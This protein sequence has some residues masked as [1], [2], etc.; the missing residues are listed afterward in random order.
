MQIVRLIIF[1]IVFLSIFA[2]M[3]LFLY[4]KLK[5]LF[6]TPLW[7]KT[8][9]LLLLTLFLI[10]PISRNLPPQFLPTRILLMVA[11]LWIG[12][13]FYSFLFLFLSLPFKGSLPNKIALL[14]ALLTVIF[15]FMQSFHIR[16]RTL[17]LHITREGCFLSGG[18]VSHWGQTHQAQVPKWGQVSSP[19]GKQLWS[20]LGRISERE[21][22]QDPEEGQVWKQKRPAS[23]TF[24]TEKG[25]VQK[26]PT[27]GQVL[28][29]R[30]VFLSDLHISI[31]PPSSF[32]KS[33]VNRINSLK[34]D[35]ILMGGAIIEREGLSRKKAQEILRCLKAPYGVFAITGNH[36]KYAGPEALRWLREAGIKL[37]RNE[38]VQ[39]GKFALIGVDDEEFLG[40]KKP[41]LTSLLEKIGDKPFI[42]LKH[43]PTHLS[44]I[45]QKGTGLILSGHTHRGQLFPL[46]FITSKV[47][48]FFYGLYKLNSSCLYVSSGVFP[49]GPPLRV[50]APGEIVLITLTFEL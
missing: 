44:L 26:T 13:L 18:Q 12:F 43:R 45:C 48:P 3:H 11:Y 27:R 41:L 28:T 35:L 2:G 1:L 40:D 16:L 33:L 8:L 9:K 5:N 50:G 34:P 19:G 36:E 20:Q 29:L 6:P 47:Y 42:L 31:F 49:W 23:A 24:P 17:N 39:M 30:V 15:G 21:R 32:L 46:H 22:T 4:W 37:L 10:V 38:V 14:L 25:Q 7:K